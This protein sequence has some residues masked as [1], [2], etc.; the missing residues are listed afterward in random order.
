MAIFVNQSGYSINGQKHAT[1]VDSDKYVLYKE[2]GE[3]VAEGS[4][5]LSFEETSG[6]MA[7]LIDF[8]NI[9]ETG[10][11]YFV[12]GN[13]NKSPRFEIKKEYCRDTIIPTLKMF[14]FQRCG[15][16]L[17]EKFAGIY[18]HKMCHK[19][20]VNELTGDLKNYECSGGWH[21]A[22]D[23][24]RYTTAGAVA[25]VHLL[26]AYKYMPEAYTDSVNIPESGNG[27][28]DILNEARYEIEW[29]LKMQK[30]DGGVYHK[31]TAMRHAPMIMPE[32]DLD[33]FIVTP[34]SSM[35]VADFAGT[36]ALA[37][38]IYK[39]FDAS[40][41]EKLAKVATL[42]G[43]WLLANPE[44]L[45]ANPENV[46]TG[47]YADGNDNDERFFAYTELFKLTG[48]EK[49]RKAMLDSAEKLENITGLG[50]GFVPGFASVR[51][52]LEE[53]DNFDRNLYERSLSEWLERADKITAKMAENPFDISLSPRE[54]GWG[55]NM[56]FGTDGILLGVA[57]MLT[58]NKKYLNGVQSCMDYIFG[59]NALSTSYVTGI[60]EKYVNNVH[61]RPTV[62]DGI[63][64][65]IPGFVS[66]GANM[67]RADAAAKEFIPEG[68]PAQKSFV[69]NIYS[70][71]TNE[72]AIYWNSP[73][74][75]SLGV[76]RKFA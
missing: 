46:R 6:D 8:S 7:G 21:D 60:G 5:E 52:L 44:F 56:R 22:G 2:S 76:L 68:T 3:K 26:L 63:E 27:I 50:W 24:G 38:E 59:R 39:H 75:F 9:T 29:M 49:Y 32:E 58:D 71:S 74:V 1:V 35:A 67:Y 51:I 15:C 16:A 61:N 55:S 30:K 18:T 47:S 10:K 70:Y 66:G 45:F 36:C 62:S 40:F 23:F 64:R 42:S 43:E 37:S 13:G 41:S 65:A 54:F 57:Y 48:E 11:Y 69:D 4:A 73:V 53:K 19:G 12:D 34:V 33:Q 31:C 17:E 25:V 28:P 20:L 72:I 14:Y